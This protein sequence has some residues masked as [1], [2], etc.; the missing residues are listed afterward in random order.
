MLS[1]RKASITRKEQWVATDFSTSSSHEVLLEDLSRLKYDR[2]KLFE[3]WLSCQ[4][5]LFDKGEFVEDGEIEA[6]SKVIS[7]HWL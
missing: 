6:P 2:S 5:V 3:N 1:P 4:M 7:I